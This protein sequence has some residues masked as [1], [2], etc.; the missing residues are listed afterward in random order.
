MGVGIVMF[1]HISHRIFSLRYR[2]QISSRPTQ[3]QQ[4]WR[5]EWGTKGGRRDIFPLHGRSGAHWWKRGV[6]GGRGWNSQWYERFNTCLG[7]AEEYCSDDELRPNVSWMMPPSPPL[8][9][10]LEPKP[11]PGGKNTIPENDRSLFQTPLSPTWSTPWPF[12]WWD[13]VKKWYVGQ[14]WF[15]LSQ[16]R[17]RIHYVLSSVFL[18]EIV[19][20]DIHRRICSVAE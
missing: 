3:L 16:D 4:G 20:P 18:G 17:G 6:G 9:S 1:R 12:A 13:H 5:R 19:P 15:I 8:I 7:V 10:L 2:P 11:L 14:C